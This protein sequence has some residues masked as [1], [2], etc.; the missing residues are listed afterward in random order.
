VERSKLA[1]PIFACT[2]YCF[3]LHVSFSIKHFWLTTALWINYV[4]YYTISCNSTRRCPLWS[5]QLIFIFCL[6][7]L[8]RS[9]QILLFVALFH[10]KLLIIYADILIQMYFFDILF[11]LEFWF[12]CITSAQIK[13]YVFFSAC[14][15]L[16]CLWPF[17]KQARPKIP[18][19]FIWAQCPHTL[20]CMRKMVSYSCSHVKVL[21]TS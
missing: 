17:S 3:C 1:I 9:L 19:C 12:G 4:Y 20:A 2:F 15:Y 21:E 7:H 6:V 16:S 8:Y 10:W 14:D 11:L 5:L 13:W 18:F